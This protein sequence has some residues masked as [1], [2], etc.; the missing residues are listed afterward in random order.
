MRS[1]PNT[2]R[3]RYNIKDKKEEEAA[4]APAT[5]NGT[6]AITKDRKVGREIEME[7]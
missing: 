1:G 6:K 3:E 7:D 2:C 5:P 4:M